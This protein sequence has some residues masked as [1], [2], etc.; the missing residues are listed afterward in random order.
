MSSIDISV[1]E[2]IEEVELMEQAGHDLLKQGFD[3][4]ISDFGGT[5]TNTA[6][7]GTDGSGGGGKQKFA[8]L[9][10]KLFGPE[11]EHIQIRF[12]TKLT[13]GLKM[14]KDD[15]MANLEKAEYKLYGRLSIID[16]FVGQLEHVQRRHKEFVQHLDEVVKKIDYKLIDLDE[17]VTY[18]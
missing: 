16:E 17:K 18:C 15:I 12:N 1:E 2:N 8:M 14:L 11:L 5:N 13:Q 9:K 10:K 6:N 7:T 4:N 3:Q